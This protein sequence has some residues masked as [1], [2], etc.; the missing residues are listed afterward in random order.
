MKKKIYRSL[1]DSDE[2]YEVEEITDNPEV[3]TDN[4]SPVKQDDGCAVEN[5]HTIEDCWNAIQKLSDAIFNKSKKEVD[6]NEPA[7]TNEVTPQ[8]VEIDKS[9]SVND[10]EEVEEEEIVEDADESEEDKKSEKEV[11]DA[12]S[13]F[14][15]VS[16]SVKQDPILATQVAFQ[17]RYNNVANK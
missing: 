8:K 15:K 2:V 16:D 11:K 9:K 13:K 3:S 12:Y 7:N 6:D 5:G 10:D 14:A 1:F 4:I 17:S